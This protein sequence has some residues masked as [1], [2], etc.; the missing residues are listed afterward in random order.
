MN[1]P[2]IQKFV[3]V[4]SKLPAIGPRMATRLAF[5]ITSQ[6]QLQNNE[7]SGAI[8]ALS[9]LGRCKQCFFI[10]EPGEDLCAIC[11]DKSRSNDI[12]AIVEKETDLISVERTGVFRGVYLV[13]GELN[14]QGILE[15][16]QK[17]KLSGLKN[18]I[19]EKNNGKIREIII[20]LGH[21]TF[22]DFM[23]DTIK[24]GFRGMADKITRLGRGIP[25]GGEIEFADDE[26][27]KNALDGRV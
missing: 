2:E 5:Y 11:L 24:Q 20:A 4:F 18:R 12:V 27:L 17:E 9:N 7:L 22:S 21:N 19:K 6:T 25:T 10:S 26:T 15:Q 23:T 14:K 1:I 16:D 3:D 13:L 8:S